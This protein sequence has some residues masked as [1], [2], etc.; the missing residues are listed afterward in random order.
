ML[1]F[2][3]A[4]PR[5]TAESRDMQNPKARQNFGSYLSP[6]AL[7]NLGPDRLRRIQ[8]AYDAALSPGTRTLYRKHWSNFEAW[9][10]A[11]KLTS[12]PAEPITVAAYIVER[13]EEVAVATIRATLSAIRS[14]HEESGWDSPT[15]LRLIRRLVRS[16]AIQDPQAPGQVTGIDRDAFEAITAAA[17]VL[18]KHESQAMADRRATFDIALISFMRDS[19][20]R[21]SEAAR[22]QWSHVQEMDDGSFSLDI[23]VSKTDQEG[24]GPPGSL[25]PETIEA[26]ANMLQHRRTLP[27]GPEERIFLIGE[28]QIANRIKAAAKHAGINARISG[29][30]PRVGM[31]LDL[32]TEEI[33][34]PALLQ[35]GRWTSVGTAMKYIS[36][37]VASKNGVARYNQRQR[38]LADQLAETERRH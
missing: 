4:G 18:K 7:E 24:K 21:R 27:T 14:Q 3:P 30:S 11:N 25:T 17:H 1:Y 26:L 16:F 22:A 6:K 20:L 28:R 13:S 29:H 35:A 36:R 15:T 33:E 5:S 19:M 9:C 12:L 8:E 31:A 34:M 37:I 2:G 32:A 23:P 10:N 38:E